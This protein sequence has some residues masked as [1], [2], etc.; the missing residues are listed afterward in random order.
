ML[1][2]RRRSGVVGA[3]AV[4][5]GGVVVVMVVRPHAAVVVAHA[6]YCRVIG[7]VLGLGDAHPA[8][9]SSGERQACGDHHQLAHHA[10]SSLALNMATGSRGPG[11]GFDG[12]MVGAIFR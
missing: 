9:G 8:G 12:T 6:L 2:R 4:A 5:T 11:P 1:F 3:V 10:S 7:A